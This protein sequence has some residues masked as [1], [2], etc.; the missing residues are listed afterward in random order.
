MQSLALTYR[1]Q[2]FED[3]VGQHAAQVLLRKMV[4][5]RV[6]PQA[7]LFEGCRGTG[8]TTTARIVAAAL[9]CTAEQRPCSTCPSCKAVTDGSSMDVI[10]IDAA[11]NGLVDDIRALRQQVLYRAPGAYRIVIFDEAHSASTAAFNAFLK[12]LEEPPPDTIFIFCTTEPRK[13]PDTIASRCIPF[14]FRRLAIADIVQRLT[15]IAHAEGHTVEPG[16]LTLLAERADGAMRDA[17][18]LLD[19]VTR[20][21]MTTA[22]QYQ[23]L[24]GHVDST[25]AI[26]NAIMRGDTAASFAALDEA[27]TRVA[28]P[29]TVID[30]LTT[31]LRDVLVLRTGGELAKT[32][33][34]LAERQNLALA[35]ETPTVAAAMKVLWTLKVT[36]RIGDTR[37]MLELA[38]VMLEEI[39]AKPAAPTPATPPAPARMTLAQMGQLR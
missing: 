5:D 38:I 3:L 11:S 8:K 19:Q 27:L 9:N 17:I 22:E 18:M 31:L 37:S 28:D 20:V 34:A 35:L 16:L 26:I 24:I 15:D 12:T 13:I 23:R 21:G 6:V 14:T 2:R 30:D 1:P 29:T 7:M 10:E 25:P 36:T 32:G 33:I 39:L 4:T